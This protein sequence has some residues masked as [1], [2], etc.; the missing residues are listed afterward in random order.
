MSLTVADTETPDPRLVIVFA[1]LVYALCVPRFTNYTYILLLVPGLFVLRSE[2]RRA[3][4]VLAAV[5]V[6]LPGAMTL[7]AN[8]PLLRDVLPAYHLL[9]VLLRDYLPL[10]SAF[11]LW[12]L[13]LRRLRVP[14][15]GVK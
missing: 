1:C 9:P 6:L 8:L 11:L 5:L 14:S 12:G 2:P 3:W 10:W 7:M 13:L 4:A 15:D